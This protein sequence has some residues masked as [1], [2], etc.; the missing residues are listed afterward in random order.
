MK[1]LRTWA[2][3]AALFAVAAADS[4]HAQTGVRRLTTID[5]LRRFSSYFHLQNVILRGEFAET[6]DRV[7]FRGG[8]NEMRVMLNDSTSSNG[9]VEIRAVFILTCASP[10]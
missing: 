4:S 1:G 7:V 8:D 10:C 2:F 6:G 9:P 3:A 5:A